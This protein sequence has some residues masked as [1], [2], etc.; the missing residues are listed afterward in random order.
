MNFSIGRAN[1][2]VRNFI[3]MLPFRCDVAVLG[4]VLPDLHTMVLLY[5]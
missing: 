1:F 2:F 3:G 4:E 5:T